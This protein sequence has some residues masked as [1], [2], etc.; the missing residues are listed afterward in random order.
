MYKQ[1]EPIRSTYL[2]GLEAIFNY[3][4]LGFFYWD[5]F[6]LKFQQIARQLVAK[7]YDY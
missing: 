4:L 5:F 6:R 1:I 2:A 3:D 7:I